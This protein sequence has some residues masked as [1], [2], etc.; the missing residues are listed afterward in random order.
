MNKNEKNKVKERGRFLEK[1]KRGALNIL[2]G[3]SSIIVIL[4]LIQVFYFFWAFTRLQNYISVVV[5]ASVVAIAIS[6][7]YLG[8]TT[9][10]PEVKLSWMIIVFVV[11]IVGAVI[12]MWVHLDLGYYLESKRLKSIDETTKKY[13]FDDSALTARLD[14]ENEYYGATKYLKNTGGFSAYENT[15]VKYYPSGE[16]YFEALIE[17]IEK[18]EKFIFLE[19]FIIDDGY[20]WDRI[21]DILKKKASEGVDVRLM[22]D[23]MC[24]LYRFPYGYPK[25]LQKFGIKCRM[26]AP[27]HPIISTSYNNR[28]HRKI[29]VV[30]GKVAFT[31]GVNLADEYI[32]V[33][34]RFG[35]WKDAAVSVRGDAVY[36][37]TLM[38]LKMW[39]VYEENCEYE[40]FLNVEHK[41]CQAEGY[42]V[43]YGDSPLDH[44]RMGENVYLDIINRAKKYVY[45]MSPYLIL[46]GIM[47]NALT[48]ASKRGVD[49]RIILPHIPDKKYAF[50]LAKSHYF[51][52][53]GAGVR[54]YEYA[55]GFIHSKV[56]LSDDSNA[57]VGTI[58][59]D[60]RSLYL[61]FECALYMKDVPAISDIYDDFKTT[62]YECIE[63]TEESIKN[64]KF[65]TKLAGKLLKWIAPLM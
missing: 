13:N 27:I 63:V 19:F 35:K 65:T 60:Y 7:I 50:A 17:E 46:D 4:I 58:N 55:P 56:F 15:S 20:M 18:A 28:D 61:H 49:V 2:F 12:Y 54:I 36:G 33:K 6:L 40:R 57:V 41:E 14:G 21:L 31:G 24:A 29:L 38:F 26:F 5:S 45:I 8:S 16:T 34:Q 48:L 42:V 32:N 30:D 10:S 22:Y 25:E 64:E 44:E 47:T 51:E 1:G 3:K 23:G 39:N 43:P 37:F 59:L 52:L 53:I 11:P 62:F 9:S